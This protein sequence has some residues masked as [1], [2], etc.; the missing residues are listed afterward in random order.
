MYWDHEG[1]GG[2]DAGRICR[3]LT[4]FLDTPSF[5]AGW[6]AC[7]GDEKVGYALASLVYSFEHG[8]LMAEID[9]LYVMEGRRGAG[10]GRSLLVAARAELS[11]RGCVALQM[12]VAVA[13]LPAQSLYRRE[14]FSPR[15]DFSL[16][17]AP[18]DAPARG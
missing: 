12:Q 15:D 17:F 6:I 11:A 7:D 2:F 9:E 4:Q 5:G 3:Q 16:W 14:G 13:N 8:G 18:L 1:I 10:I